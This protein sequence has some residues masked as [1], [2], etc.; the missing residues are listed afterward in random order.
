MARMTLDSAC[1]P[2]RE[3]PS[4]TDSDAS[5]DNPFH[6]GPS[7]TIPATGPSHRARGH[8]FAHTDPTRQM[9]PTAPK[10][11]F[12]R[13][14]G[15]NPRIWKSKCEDYF[16]L[17]SVPEAMKATFASLHM[18]DNSA[19]WL[20]MY[21]KK[22]GLTVWSKFIAAVEDKFG[23]SDYRDA[24]SEL[25]DL[26]QTST[27]EQYATAFENLQFEICMHHDGYDDLFFVSQ[28]IKGLK[29]E[30][31]AAVQSQLPPTLDRA[32]LL[33][34]VQQ[35]V[36]EKGKQKPQRFLSPNKQSYAPGKFES[37]SSSTT[38]VVSKE[39]QL[40]NYRKARA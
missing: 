31:A 33:A 9:K 12:P 32:I 10:L 2:D 40:L 30:I 24:I 17:Y 14:D 37:K 29:Y 1:R 22:Y 16:Q 3:P 7:G 26:T 25:L 27:V 34:K 23:A 18:D 6:L 28:F 39:R 19:K 13:F 35:Q 38:P 8:S 4:P 5:V 15:S 11:S 21:K 36:L 20:Q